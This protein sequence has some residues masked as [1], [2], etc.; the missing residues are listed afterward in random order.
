MIGRRTTLHTILVTSGILSALLYVSMNVFIPLRW[1]EYSALSQT[2]SELSAIGAPTRP[3]WVALG[4]VYTLLVAAFGCGLWVTAR[5]SRRLRLAGGLLAFDGVFGL[6]WPPMHLRG[7]GFSVTDVLHIVWTI[8]TLLIMLLVMG[9]AAAEFGK[10]FRVFTLAIVA[11]WLVCG[12][13][14]GLEG[15]RVA[16]NLPTPVIGVW[17]RINAALYQL[18]VVV[19]AIMLLRRRSSP[20]PTPRLAGRGPGGEVERTARRLP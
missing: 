4:I 5:G 15:P 10:R 8:V 9:L 7:T 1:A 11:I 6:F 3:L 14:T 13:L 20:V 2:I 18:W 19:F 17:E 12:T 16:A